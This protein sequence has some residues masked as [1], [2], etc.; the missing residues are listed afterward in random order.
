MPAPTLGANGLT[1]TGADGKAGPSVTTAGIDAGGKPITNVGAGTNGTDAANMAQVKE[2]Q[3]N[4]KCDNSVQYD[5]NAERTERPA[6][7]ASAWAARMLRQA[8]PATA[9]VKLGNVADGNVAAGSKDAVNGGQL[10]TTNQNVTNLGDSIATGT[11]GPVQVVPGKTDQLTLVAPGATAAT[12]GN[13]QVLG[14]VAGGKAPT[15]AVNVGSSMRWPAARC[16]TTRTRT[17]HRARTA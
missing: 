6:R 15:D 4:D 10:N 9:P 8:T 1:T 11:I 17:A 5:K 14:N 7:K 12:P 2:A 16:S 3:G 13:A